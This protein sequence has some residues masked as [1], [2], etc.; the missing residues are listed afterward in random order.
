[1]A[2]RDASGLVLPDHGPALLIVDDAE[3]VDDPDGSLL[4]LVTRPR[5]G[6]LVVA[7]AR[8]EAL[9]QSYG[10]WTGAVRRSRLGVVMAGA[11]DLDADLLGA[12]LPRW[13]PVEPRPGLA[14]L[15]CDGTVT[16]VQVA[17]DTQAE[18]HPAVALAAVS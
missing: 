7:A 18:A 4:Q 5:R 2:R 17:R 6:A 8:P 15:V 14:H 12:T 13:L 11:T 3:L 10:H 16:L 1:M 9:R